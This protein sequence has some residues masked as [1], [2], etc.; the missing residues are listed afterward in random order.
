MIG[1]NGNVE[2]KVDASTV[3]LLYKESHIGRITILCREQICSE[4]TS[5]VVDLRCSKSLY[6][7]GK[8]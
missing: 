2:S 6:S 5:L 8:N 3:K 4:S 7:L 1:V